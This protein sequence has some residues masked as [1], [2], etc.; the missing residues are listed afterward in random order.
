MQPGA[1]CHPELREQTI[2]MCTDG[3]RR[4]KQL[5]G[6]LLV[7]QACG[8]QSGDAAF[9]CAQRSGTAGGQVMH[10]GAC[11]AKLVA[12][13]LGP[14]FCAQA[15]EDVGSGAERNTGGAIAAQPTKAHPVA[16]P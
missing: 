5:R 11:G 15:R 2:Q 4:Q 16:Q 8:G 14:W 3:A 6:D 1:G 13:S 10:G 7:G 12:G 9:L